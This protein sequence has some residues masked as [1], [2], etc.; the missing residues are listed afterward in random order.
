MT[1]EFQRLTGG[2]LEGPLKLKKLREWLA[3]NGCHLA[4][5]QAPTVDKALLDPSMDETVRRVLR[6]AGSYRKYPLQN[7]QHC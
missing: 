6:F 7:I 1:E 4:N 3:E 5:L 2:M